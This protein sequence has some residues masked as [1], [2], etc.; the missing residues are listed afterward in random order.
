MN[1]K[2]KNDFDYKLTVSFPNSADGIQEF[3]PSDAEKNSALR[4]PYE[5]PAEGYQSELVKKMSRHSGH[6]AI[7]EMNDPN[8][9]YF[10]R[11]RTVLDGRGK[12][13]SALYG[14]VY[15]DFMQFTYYLNPTSNDRNV[16]FD[17]S[18]NLLKSAKSFDQVN[19]P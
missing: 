15:G 17:T 18:Q 4:S 13:K 1:Q 11:V 5:A 8:R 14:K 9:N 19:A 3:T 10:I 12:I 6:D 16:E 7:N 2:A